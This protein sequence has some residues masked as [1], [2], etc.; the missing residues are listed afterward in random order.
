MQLISV[1][2]TQ[3]HLLHGIVPV[4]LDTVFLW[5]L[6]P[7]TSVSKLP[8]HAVWDLGLFPVPQSDD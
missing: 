2:F 1:C 5:L 4:E 6:C 8:S 7:S 3:L